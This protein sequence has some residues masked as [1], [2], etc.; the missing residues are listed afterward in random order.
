MFLVKGRCDNLKVKNTFAES[1][2]EDAA[3]KCMNYERN[4]L[5]NKKL[6]AKILTTSQIKVDNK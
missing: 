4:L 2:L 3:L 1:L 6:V 5:K